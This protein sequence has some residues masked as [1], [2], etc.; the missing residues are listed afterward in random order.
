MPEPRHAALRLTSMRRIGTVLAALLVTA[1]CGSVDREPSS[2]ARTPEATASASSPS[3]ST[4]AEACADPAAAG[5]AVSS[6]DLDGDGSEDRVR[7]VAARGDCPGRLAVTVASTSVQVPL[8][9]GQPP[10]R[11]A[12]GVDVPGRQGSLL[13]TRQDHPRGGF[14]LRVYGLDDGELTELRIGERSLVPFVALDVQEHPWSIDCGD[15][16]VVFTEA[17]AHEPAGVMF[18]WDIR[19]TAYA[20]DGNEVTAGP[21]METAD[22]ILPKQLAKQYPDLEKHTAFASCRTAG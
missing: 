6:V 8:P 3:P 1:A 19:R 11:T 21:T 4:P 9:A 5:S 15:G 2:G 14:Q 22:N 13:L 7:L 18:T 17:V 10:V 16:G 20:V 12:F